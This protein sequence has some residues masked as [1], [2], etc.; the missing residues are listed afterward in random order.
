LF[1]KSISKILDNQSHILI[2]KLVKNMLVERK[3]DSF[4]S[5]LTDI[6]HT[7]EEIK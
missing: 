6:Y 1:E 4:E 5:L 3:Y 7:K 2:A